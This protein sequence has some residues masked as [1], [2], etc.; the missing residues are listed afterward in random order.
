MKLNWFS[1]LS[2]KEIFFN[3][4]FTLLFLLNVSLGFFGLFLLENFKVGIDQMVS[5]RSSR[6]LGADLSMISRF[7]IASEKIKTSES[8]LGD[9]LKDKAIMRSLFSM[10]RIGDKA[11]L[12]YLVS[13]DGKFPFYGNLQLDAKDY[14]PKSLKQPSEKEVWVYSDVLELLSV[15]KGDS[16]KIGDTDFIISR[17]VTDDPQQGLQMG[18]LAPK[19]YISNKGLKRANL[20]RPGS[21]VRY[22]EMYKL[23]RKLSELE[24]EDLQKKLDDNALRL[25]TPEKSAQRVSRVVNYLNDFLGL[26]SL[27]ALFLACVGVFYLYRSHL[28]SKRRQMAIFKILGMPK[29]QVFRMYCLHLFI[30]GSV[31][32]LASILVAWISFPILN[33]FLVNFLS[34]ELKNSFSFSKFF[35]FYA[36]G[37][38]GIF[39]LGLPLI[40]SFLK[41]SPAIAFQDLEDISQA[42]VASALRY[43]PFFIYFICL[44]FYS[45]NSFKVGGLFLA[46]FL[47]SALLIFPISFQFLKTLKAFT[48]KVNLVGRLAVLNLIRFRW[49]SVVIFLTLSMT[50]I[51]MGLIPQIQHNITQELDLNGP[52]AKPS[53]FL[54]DI[55]DEQIQELRQFLKDDQIEYLGLSPMVR[56]RFI[57]IN[58][59]L[60]EAS[61]EKKMTREEQAEQRFRN[62]GINLSFREELTHSE[63]IVEG[64]ELVGKWDSE[65]EE[66]PPVSIEQNY[67]RRL[68]IKIGDTL[69]FDILGVPVLA[70]VQNLRKIKWTSFIPNFFIQ[71][72][73]GV[74]DDAPKTW[75]LSLPALGEGKQNFIRRL[76]DKFP[77]IS[78]VDVSRA[79][80]KVANLISQMAL[81][82][83]FMASLS[84]IVGMMVL[85]AITSNQIQ[86]RSREF[87]LFR[88]M[89]M[90]KNNIKKIIYTEVALLS[91]SSSVV[92][93]MFSLLISWLLSDLVF[94]SPWQWTLT[95]ILVVL[96]G[97]PLVSFMTAFFVCRNTLQ[98]KASD[99]IQTSM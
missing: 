41:D 90:E 66:I 62:R 54:F 39:C 19:V 67:A 30:L 63:E 78:S 76:S 55:Q 34:F 35:S 36:T 14:Y 16:L 92:G 24:L 22:H 1:N 10:A 72:Q 80:E 21:T 75:L 50:S 11:K 43:L 69:E 61:T 82:M 23:K 47:G 3:K 86:S 56:G 99:L 59:R 94:T 88:M 53:F 89:G 68:G 49:A 5:E 57:K 64:K 8:F 37:L 48:K 6:L 18:N 85:F 15:K 32:L 26:V 79:I 97:I 70:K 73:G 81:A 25:L 51:L 4:R 46:L 9:N 44:S 96:V 83:K 60:M 71:F 2:F 38:L 87:G 95:P 84:L 91:L 28:D 65:K 42:R 29:G 27:V 52:V 7:P 45:A 74:L 93:I 13:L 77:N 40:H 33:K 20:I 17:V 12:V 98:I 31:G 58:D